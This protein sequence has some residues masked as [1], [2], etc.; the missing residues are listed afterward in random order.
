MKLKLPKLKIPDKL[1]SFK[2][3]FAI[4]LVLLILTGSA[5]ALVNYK[6]FSIK[7]TNSKLLRLIKEEDLEQEQEISE[8]NKETGINEDDNNQQEDQSIPEEEDKSSSEKNSTTETDNSSNDNET[9]ESTD[10]TSDDNEEEENNDQEEETP[11]PEPEPE[12]QPE[13]PTA[14]VA[15]YADN[16]SDSDAD[17][18][19]HQRVVNYI[20]N[21]GAN[22]I[23]HAGDVM[24][25]GTQDSL[26]RFNTVTSTLRSTR[27]F[28]AA[29][30]NNDRKVGD[31]STPSQLFLDN[32]VF[33]NN[34]R[35]YSVNY[36][37]LHMVILDS[38]FAGASSSQ[39]SWLSSDL[40]SSNSQNRI[41]GVMFHHPTFSS[42]IS[43]YLVNYGVDFVVAGHYHAY[44]H[45][46]SNG[47]DHFVLSGQPNIG[48]MIA[49]VYSDE[50]KITVYNSSNSV[51]DTITIDER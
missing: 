5:F 25:D 4:S 19:N 20:L 21:S 24:E 32:F 48:Y 33:P 47:I 50:V 23:F 44:S 13:S 45:S 2:N 15:F 29:L 35:W 16:Q 22:P 10:Q 7:D 17:D 8:T 31:S 49:R 36:G 34:E 6:D 30:G 27:T 37:N 28:Y 3:L 9:D 39:L 14:Y 12:P 18:A 51:I 42:T 1:K 11:E 43:T 38:A 40:Q 26:D 41:T 46:V